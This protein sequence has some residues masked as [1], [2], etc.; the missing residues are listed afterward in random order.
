M[1]GNTK[2]RTLN[3]R[4]SDRGYDTGARWSPFSYTPRSN[5]EAD[6]KRRRTITRAAAK[7][8]KAT[9]AAETKRKRI[10]TKRRSQAVADYAV[11][12]PIHMAND[13]R[14]V[15]YF[16]PIYRG[17]TKFS[18]KAVREAD[19]GLELLITVVVTHALTD[20]G[21]STLI[22]QARGITCPH[23]YVQISGIWVRRGEFGS[24]AE[25]YKDGGTLEDAPLKPPAWRSLSLSNRAVVSSVFC[26]GV[27]VATSSSARDERMPVGVEST[28]AVRHW[29]IETA[30]SIERRTSDELTSP[31]IFFKLTMDY[32]F[33][34]L[35]NKPPSG[36]LE[37]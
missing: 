16:L 31:I 13:H 4:E 26:V 18:V 8:T 22:P 3:E 2:M 28:E 34:P 32:V 11:G 10:R 30:W 36:E 27:V 5:C 21:N 12:Y 37:L 23:Q 29:R 1:T 9:T 17:S 33:E 7:Q 20:D 24:F 6:M 15:P 19:G 14:S 25:D 35:G